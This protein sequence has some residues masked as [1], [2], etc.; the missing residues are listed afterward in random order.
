MAIVLPLRPSIGSYT[1]PLAIDDVQ[2][3]FAIRWNSRERNGLGAWFMDVSEF[4][5]TPILR[6]QKIV[7]GTYLGRWSLHPLLLNGVFAPRSNAPIGVDPVFDTLGV[8]VQ[9]LYF[10]RA[11][12][13]AELMAASSEAT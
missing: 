13:A 12:L 11:D 2:Y 8:T 1:F 10:N 9:V 7:L 3:Q 4:D 5:G 6:G